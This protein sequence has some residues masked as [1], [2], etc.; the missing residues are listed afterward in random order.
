MGVRQ[1]DWMVYFIGNPTKMD[2]F[3]VPPFQETSK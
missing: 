2:D 1:N 3:E